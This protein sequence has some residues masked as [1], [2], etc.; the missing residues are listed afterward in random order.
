[1]NKR[2]SQVA[3]LAWGVLTLLALWL[4]SIQP[5]ASKPV[6][7]AAQFIV[8]IASGV[9]VADLWRGHVSTKLE[10][11]A[12]VGGLLV[13]VGLVGQLWPGLGYPSVLLALLQAVGVA[14]LVLPLAVPVRYTSGGGFG[15][16]YG[17]NP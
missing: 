12:G 13:L 10:M 16:D 7:T 8:F 15:G 14:F 1:M 6:L 4:T 17:R 5:D 11:L 9:R 2:L 3:F